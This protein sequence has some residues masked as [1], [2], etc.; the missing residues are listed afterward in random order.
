MLMSP[1]QKQPVSLTNLL[2]SLTIP[3]LEDIPNIILSVSPCRSGTTAMLRVMSALGTKAYFQPLKNLLR[4]QMQGEKQAW[5]VSPGSADTIYIK[6]TLGPYS[7]AESTFNPLELLL[8]AGVPASKLHLLLYGRHPLDSYVSWKKWW[9]TNTHIDY[10]VASYHTT[11]QVYKQAKLAG[12][13]T[14]AL[15]YEIFSAYPATEVIQKLAQHMGL[16]YTEHAVHGWE[17]LP[18]FGSPASNIFLPEEPPAFVVESIHDSVHN[19]TE[20]VYSPPLQAVRALISAEERHHMK[21]SDLFDIY[22]EWQ[23]ACEK[24]LQLPNLISQP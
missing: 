3:D 9:H 4:W 6:E 14:T 8:N 19:A 21:K 24:D 2:L 16:A 7:L 15:S 5:A 1:Y 22:A 11:N 18:S 23:V 10:F 13:S 17:H 12:I 20:F